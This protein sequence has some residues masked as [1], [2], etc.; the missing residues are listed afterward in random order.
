MTKLT[1]DSGHNKG[2]ICHVE[3]SVDCHG[4]YQVIMIESKITERRTNEYFAWEGNIS[5]SDWS[6]MLFENARQ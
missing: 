2:V 4:G 5:V 6:D 1:H 3:E